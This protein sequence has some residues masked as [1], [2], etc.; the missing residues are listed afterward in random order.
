MREKLLT[1]FLILLF[2]SA[3]FFIYATIKFGI[4]LFWGVL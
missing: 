2:L 4:E 1:S 3:T